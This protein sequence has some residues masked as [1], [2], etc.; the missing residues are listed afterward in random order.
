MVIERELGAGGIGQVFLARDERLQRQV[1][2]KLLPVERALDRSARL[3]MLRE[4]RSA[5]AL[6]HPGIVAVYD[7]GEHDGR[8]FIAMEFVEGETL[9]KFL[10]RRGKLPPAEAVELLAAFGDAVSAAHEAGCCIVT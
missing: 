6:Q 3:R 7:V 4:A 8:A 9:D 10:E 2:V 1:A 5:S